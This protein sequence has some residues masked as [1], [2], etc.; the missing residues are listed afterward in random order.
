MSVSYTHLDVYKRQPLLNNNLHKTKYIK[1][2]FSERKGTYYFQ[3]VRL[4]N[5]CIVTEVIND[6][7]Y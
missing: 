6:Q 3:T 7:R 5:Y 1:I 2:P 4:R